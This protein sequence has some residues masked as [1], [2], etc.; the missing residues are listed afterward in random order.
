[1]GAVTWPV[2]ELDQIARLKVLAAAMPN[3]GVGEVVLDLPVEDVWS[4]L[5]DFEHTTHKFDTE[6]R[7][8]RVRRRTDRGVK[9]WAWARLTPI[10]LG[11]DVTIE[12]GFCLM[13]GAGR[14]FVV[15]M[16][17]VPDG[18]GGTRYAH[19][20]AVPRRG[21]GWLRPMLQRV[22]DSDLRRLRRVVG[23]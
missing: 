17:A 4:W 15:V 7:K 20:E 5:M 1:V 2:A 8:V 14:L 21:L 9:I 12:P 3:A 23:T 10:P 22:V 18:E 6:V 19:A 11:F 13:R 16:A